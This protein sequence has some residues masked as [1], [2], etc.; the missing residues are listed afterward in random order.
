MMMKPNLKI[1]LL[2][3][4]KGLDQQ[5]MPEKLNISIADY[6]KMGYF[7]RKTKI[8]HGHFLK[9]TSVLKESLLIT[10]HRKN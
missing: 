4:L 7:K 10:N 8:H 9:I 3:H 1:R 6:S 5:Q 2:R